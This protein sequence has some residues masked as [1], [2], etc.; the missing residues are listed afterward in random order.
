MPGGVLAVESVGDF[1]ASFVPSLRD[2]SRLDR[3]FRLPNS[4]WN[5]IPDYRDYSFAVFQLR[6]TRATPS[7]VHPMALEFRTRLPNTIYFPTVHIHDGRVHR[8]EHFDH[9]LYTQDPRLYPSAPG[10]PA[11]AASSKLPLT[12]SI[13]PIGSFVDPKRAQGVIDREARCYR[14]SLRGN[15]DNQDTLLRI[16]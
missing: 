16:A 1:V 15:L 11:Y 7:E 13:A 12:P 4:V 14:L 2:F 9:S 8:T 3:R 5:Q 6:E 10:H